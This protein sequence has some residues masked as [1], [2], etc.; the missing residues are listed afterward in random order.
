LNIRISATREMPD[1]RKFVASDQPHRRNSND[2]LDPRNECPLGRLRLRN[3]ITEAEYAAGCR[4]RTIYH[5]WLNSIGAPNPFPASVGIGT[6]G[7]TQELLDSS[8]I[9]DE[10]AEMIAKAFKTGERELKK[11]GPRVFHAVNAIVVYEEPDE[12]GDFEF[13]AMAAKKGLAA[14]A[15]V[16]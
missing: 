10:A 6:G 16:F 1:A 14:L 3:K 11:L 12:L 8:G 15:Q 7:H 5:N 2:P 4:W 13:T 9:D